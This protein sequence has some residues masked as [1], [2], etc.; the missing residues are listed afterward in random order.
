MARQWL[1][2]GASIAVFAM[3]AAAGNHEIKTP[4]IDIPGASNAMKLRYQGLG[5]GDYGLGVRDWGL[6]V[7]D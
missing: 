3:Y 1:A 7:G 4:T 5:I 6:G 2:G